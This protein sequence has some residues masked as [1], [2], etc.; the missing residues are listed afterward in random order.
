MVPEEELTLGVLDRGR[1]EEVAGVAEEEVC[2][3]M[4]AL[5]G[6]V[7]GEV[8]DLLCSEEVG[9]EGGGG[10]VEIRVQGNPWELG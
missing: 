4:D 8:E 1:D 3:G 7:Q 9:T 10:V 5:V 2:K 6:F